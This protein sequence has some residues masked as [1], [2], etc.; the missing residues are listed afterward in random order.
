MTD[1]IRRAVQFLG[2][3]LLIAV[4]LALGTPELA[5]RRLEPPA[6]HPSLQFTAAGAAAGKASWLR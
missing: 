3:W 5:S 6:T 1:Q 2:L 4:V